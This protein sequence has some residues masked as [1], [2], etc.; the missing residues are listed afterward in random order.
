MKFKPSEALLR[1]AE[2]ADDRDHGGCDAIWVAVNWNG[3]KSLRCFN[4]FEVVGSGRER[5]SYWWG[6]PRYASEQQHNARVLGLLFAA[7]MAKS[8]GE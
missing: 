3:A 7:E 4:H 6:I 8:A 2:I 1:A 5:G